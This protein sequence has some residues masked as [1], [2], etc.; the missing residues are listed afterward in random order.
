MP[1]R[2]KHKLPPNRQ[3]GAL[4]SV[5]LAFLAAYCFYSGSTSLAGVLGIVALLL[6]LL[7]IFNP[8]ALRHCNQAWMAFGNL[9]SR[10]ISPLLLGLIYFGVI[11]PVALIMRMRGRDELRLKLKDRPSHWVYRDECHHAP[12]SFSKQ[13]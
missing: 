6:L 2:E 9:I 11:T 8:D 12:D 3:F 13:F 10:I 4:F 5:I 1:R 7:T